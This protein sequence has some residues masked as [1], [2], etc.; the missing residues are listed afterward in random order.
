MDMYTMLYLKWKTNKGL[1]Y[2][3]G[4]LL[5]VMWQPGWEGSLGEECMCACSVTSVVS[6]SL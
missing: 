2:T 4:N 3:T 5:S 1:L 6:D